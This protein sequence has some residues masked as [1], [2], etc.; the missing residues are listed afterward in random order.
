MEIRNIN[1]PESNI[2]Q[3]I[4]LQ[5]LSLAHYIVMQYHNAFRCPLYQKRNSPK[6]KPWRW[7]ETVADWGQQETTNAK[8]EG[9][10]FTLLLLSS[11]AVLK[12]TISLLFGGGKE[13]LIRA[14][15]RSHF[16]Q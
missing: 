3:I 11:R 12:F 2:G 4:S 15:L 14:V 16:C 1:G 6:Y 7:S 9:K 8:S 10:V 5:I 13:E